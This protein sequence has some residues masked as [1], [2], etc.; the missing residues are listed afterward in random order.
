MS[1]NIPAARKILMDAADNPNA[2]AA[3]LRQAIRDAL[4]LMTRVH[5]KRTARASVKMTPELSHEIALF[6]EDNPEMS[7]Q[8]IASRFNVN[9]G[10]VSEAVAAH[11][12]RFG[13]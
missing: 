12:W 1:T 4:P 8:A 11:A 9:P 13:N 6:K 10:R 5:T 7:M 3:E 2:D